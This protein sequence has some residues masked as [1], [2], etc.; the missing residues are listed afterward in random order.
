[1]LGTQIAQPKRIISIMSP[2]YCAI[3]NPRPSACEGE[4]YSQSYL[5]VIVVRQVPR[6]DAKSADT[7]F[8]MQMLPSTTT[9]ANRSPGASTKSPEYCC[10]GILD[11]FAIDMRGRCPQAINTITII[12]ASNAIKSPIDCWI[13]KLLSCG[14]IKSHN[15]PLDW[16]GDCSK[17]QQPIL[18]QASASDTKKVKEKGKC[19]LSQLVLQIRFIQF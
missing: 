6:M 3:T 8:V 17:F 5:Q 2:V 11:N 18:D 9:L 4:H 12:C 19:I 7:T 14:I 13:E 16:E 15:A 1:M 10:V